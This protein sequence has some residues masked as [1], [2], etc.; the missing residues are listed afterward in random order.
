MAINPRDPREG[1]DPQVGQRYS[2]SYDVVTGGVAVAESPATVRAAFI[3]KVYATMCIGVAITMGTSFMLLQGYIQNESQSILAALMQKYMFVFIAYIA[4]GVAAP[5]GAR[6][7][8]LN[9]ILYG[10]F[11]LVTGLLLGP[12]FAM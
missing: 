11:T 10:A 6:T 1:Y 7:R 9:V 4:L 2:N 3:Q 8:G 12:L 5:F